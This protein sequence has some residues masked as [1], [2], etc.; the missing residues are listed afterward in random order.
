ME[1]LIFQTDIQSED[2]VS[3]LEPV[4]NTHSDILNWSVDLED[5]DNVLRIEAKTNLTENT[6]IELVTKHGFHIKTLMD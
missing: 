1:I 2:K 3:H 6:V 4:F 5:I